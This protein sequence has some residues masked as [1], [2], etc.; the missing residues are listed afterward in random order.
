MSQRE[1]YYA[2][3]KAE[4]LKLIESWGRRAIWRYLRD[5]DLLDA[6]IA[7]LPLKDYDTTDEDRLQK[8]LIDIWDDYSPEKLEEVRTW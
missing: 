3:T 5:H 6:F 1:A 2:D 8:A 4:I 7:Q